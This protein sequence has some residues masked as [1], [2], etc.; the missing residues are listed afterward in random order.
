MASSFF[1]ESVLVDSVGFPL[2]VDTSTTLLLLG[3]FLFVAFGFKDL[4][5][6]SSSD[7]VSKKSSF[8][9]PLGVADSSVFDLFAAESR[10]SS[11]EVSE[12]S[13]ND[14]PF[15]LDKHNNDELIDRYKTFKYGK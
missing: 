12:N 3:S 10:G 1:V 7:E 9:F 14:D 6:L 11:D 8:F 2:G 13:E 4:S 15:F 5:G